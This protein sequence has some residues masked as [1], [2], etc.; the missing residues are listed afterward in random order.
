MQFL[1]DGPNS[2][3]KSRKSRQRGRAGAT[4]LGLSIEERTQ[5][6]WAE[7]AS[8]IDR[9]DAQGAIDALMAIAEL[10]GLLADRVEVAVVPKL[11]EDHSNAN[12]R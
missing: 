9:R 10:H 5:E 2:T 4:A 11:R 12:P 7:H 6:F 8:A 3:R 1:Y